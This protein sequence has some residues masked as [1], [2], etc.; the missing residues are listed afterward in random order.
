MSK[1]YWIHLLKDNP[2]LYKDRE[3]IELEFSNNKYTFIDG[4]TLKKLR[5]NEEV[6]SNLFSPVDDSACMCFEV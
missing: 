3:R 1:K 6:N 4:I 5:E 2:E